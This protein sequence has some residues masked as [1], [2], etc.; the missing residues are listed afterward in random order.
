MTEIKDSI[1]NPE[2]YSPSGW[3]MDVEDPFEEPRINILLDIHELNLLKKALMKSEASLE[4]LYLS[5]KIQ[6]AIDS[7]PFQ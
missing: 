5:V 1:F 4:E 2:S 3:R 7:H 6:K